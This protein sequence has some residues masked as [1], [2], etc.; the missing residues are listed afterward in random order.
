MLQKIIR[1]IPIKT[2]ICK[3][4]LENMRF[5]ISQIKDPAYKYCILI[6]EMKC[7]Q[8]GL[9]F[10]K[11]EDMVCDYVDNSFDRKNDVADRIL[12]WMLQIVSQENTWKQSL[13]YRF[14]KSIS[15]S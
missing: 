12:V 11:Y 9:Y 15:T 7:L 3:A 8:P 14:C 1:H 13:G 6:Y 4:V 5:R 10:S 2:G